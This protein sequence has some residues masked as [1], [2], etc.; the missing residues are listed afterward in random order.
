MEFVVNNWYLFLALFV[1]LA[2]LFAGP[3]TQMIH[4]I[5]SVNN[6]EAV[7]L[8]N[9]EA[10]MVVDVCEPREYQSGHILNAV[11]IPLSTLAARSKELEKHKSKPVIV[12]CQSGNRSVRGAVILR[13]HG[14]ASVYTLSGGNLAWQRDN[15][16]ME[17]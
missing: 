5:K 12:S 1:V 11:N 2:M 16:P 6:A 17:K 14:F 8:M 13:K 7:R 4:N 15:L 3:I 9:H 10:G